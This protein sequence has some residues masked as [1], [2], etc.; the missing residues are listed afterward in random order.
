MQWISREENNGTKKFI[1][2][3]VDDDFK[4]WWCG[5]M[6]KIYHGSYID[7]GSSC[8]I[9]RNIHIRSS[10]QLVFKKNNSIEVCWKEALTDKE[11]NEN[12]GI[13]GCLFC[14]YKSNFIDF[15]LIKKRQAIQ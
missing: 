4:F 13:L 11:W 8:G 15:I 14:H 3:G 7:S 12:L 10:T 5:K 9:K 2:Y 6:E 1:F